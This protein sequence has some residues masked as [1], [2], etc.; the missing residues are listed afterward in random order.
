M[1]L[2]SKRFS[3]RDFLSVIER[4]DEVL[5]VQLD[6]LV[7]ADPA[8]AEVVLFDGSGTCT[9]WIRLPLS[10]IESIEPTGR[11]ECGDHSHTIARLMLAMPSAPEAA[12]FAA[13]A[14]FFREA[15]LNSI[16][17]NENVVSRLQVEAPDNGSGTG[18]TE[19]CEQKCDRLHPGWCN[20]LL[21]WACKNQC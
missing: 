9:K 19:T 7:K 12:A 1:H 18:V 10:I 15:A 21:R 20:A 2:P 14:G 4:V 16:V 13:L 17:Q 5:P 6:G 3:A 8:D 11:F